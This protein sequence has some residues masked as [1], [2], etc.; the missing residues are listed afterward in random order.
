[1]TAVA[2]ASRER[3]AREFPT[4]R[5]DDTLHVAELSLAAAEPSRIKITSAAG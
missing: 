2:D 3:E 4:R 1:M 5:F